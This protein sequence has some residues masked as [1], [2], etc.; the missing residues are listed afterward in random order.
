MPLVQLIGCAGVERWYTTFNLPLVSRRQVG[1]SF[2]HLTKLYW[3]NEPL[4]P[5]DHMLAKRRRTKG[6]FKLTARTAHTELI[7]VNPFRAFSNPVQYVLD[8][9]NGKDLIEVLLGN[10]ATWLYILVRSFNTYMNIL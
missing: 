1:Q 4:L 10:G 7:F 2:C 5:T 8:R 6:R 9:R 3:V